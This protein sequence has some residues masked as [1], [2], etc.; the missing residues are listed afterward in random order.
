M[1]NSYLTLVDSWK[2]FPDT[3]EWQSPD[4]NGKMSLV[5]P[6]SINEVTIGGFS[7]RGICYRDRIDR[8]VMFQLEFGIPSE[9]HKVP[10]TRIE[11]RPTSGSHKNPATLKKRGNIIVGSHLHTF[12]DN[13]LANE[14]R[15]RA[16]NLP[17]AEV[18]KP[19]PTS[20]EDFYILAMKKLKI[21]GL[22]R[23][24]VPPWEAKLV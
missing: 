5:V 16:N 4:Q 18:L 7:L 19:D 15:M 13:W 24:P 21:F 9:R 23:L 1:A 12:Q 22:D 3:A 6:L 14:G 2:D 11:W 10:L 17:F 8:D 20:V